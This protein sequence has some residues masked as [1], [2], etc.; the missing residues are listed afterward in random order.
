M[1]NAN[2]YRLSVMAAGVVGFLAA[3]LPAASAQQH[4]PQGWLKAFTKKK[5]VYI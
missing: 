1:T 3:G 2:A 4:L 5:E